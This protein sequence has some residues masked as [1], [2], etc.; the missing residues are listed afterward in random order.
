MHPTS[1]PWL[2]AESQRTGGSRAGCVS[3]GDKRLGDESN[4]HVRSREDSVQPYRRRSA[5]AVESA[6]I[7]Q[8]PT[9]QIAIVEIVGR[10]LEADPT[11]SIVRRAPGIVADARKD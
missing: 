9:V 11:A 5:R 3:S 10:I 1:A 4:R 7:P 2:M 6:R 8:H